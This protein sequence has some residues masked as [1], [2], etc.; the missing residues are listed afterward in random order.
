MWMFGDPAQAL[1]RVASQPT[2]PL[3]CS[4]VLGVVS[5]SEAKIAHACTGNT[6]IRLGTQCSESR[7][8]TWEALAT[9]GCRPPACRYD[10]FCLPCGVVEMA[11][12]WAWV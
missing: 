6:G 3:E 9:L 7:L 1:A 4:P 8:L 2:S 11:S 10:K 12:E 5:G